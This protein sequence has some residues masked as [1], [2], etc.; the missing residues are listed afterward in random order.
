MLIGGGWP[1]LSPKGS[2]GWLLP[3]GTIPYFPAAPAEP[4][5][6]AGGSPSRCLILHL[7]RRLASGQWD[8][9]I[10][11]FRDFEQRG[12]Y[13]SLVIH[14]SAFGFPLSALEQPSG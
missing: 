8:L 13:R 4:P 14:R 11:G 2:P 3:A 5:A 9:G 1:G 6:H 12:R 10:W 7:H